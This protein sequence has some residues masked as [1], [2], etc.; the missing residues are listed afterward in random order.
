MKF[1]DGYWM[2]KEGFTIQSPKEV[3][4][5]QK[6]RESLVLYAP[7]KKI[8]RRGD[9]LNLGMSTVTLSSPQSD[10]ISVKIVHH[11][12]NDPGPNFELTKTEVQPIIEE[13]TEQVTFTSG[14]LRVSAALNDKFSLRFFGDEQLLTES[15]FGAQGE[16]THVEGKHYMREQLSLGIDEQ[17][18]GLGERFTPFIK[19]GQTVD[20]W[21]EDGGTGSEQAYKNIPF[22][23]S[24][25]GYGVFVNH[26]EKV[27]FE[28][29]SENVSRA[30]FSVEGEALEYIIIYGPTPKEILE[31]Y[32]NL[33]GKPALPPAWSFG[34]WLSTSFTTDYSEQTVMKFIDGM[35][36]RDIPL[37]VFH[38]DC[39]WM[40]AF[41]WCNFK[42]DE[43]LF[44]DPKGMLQRIHEKG[45]NVCVWINPYIGQK[46]PL[47]EEG[48]KNGYFLKQADGN[49]W[50]WDM[51]Q[52]GQGIVDFTNPEAVK[53]YQ[54][55]LS[56]LL[57][58]GVDSFKTDFG[59]RIPTDAVYY[60]GSDPEKAHNYYSYLYNEA[61]FSLLEEKRGKNEAVLFAR[62]GTVGSQKFPVHWG[63][64]NLSEYVSMTETLRGGLSFLLSGFGFWSHDIGGFEENASADIYKRW[65]QFGL[66]STHS[67]YHGNIEYRVPWNYDEEAVSVTRKF[68]KLKVQL[69]PYLYQQAVYTATTGIPMM[70]PVFMEYPEDRNSYFVD[71]QY[72]LGDNLLV[73]PVFTETGEVSY[74][75]PE[76]KWTQLLDHSFKAV[77]K[78][79]QW[80]TEQHDYL[81]LPVWVKENTILVIAKNE[82]QSVVYD[83]NKDLEI[84]CYQL[85]NGTHEQLIVN[86]SGNPLAKIIIEKDNKHVMIRTEGLIGENDVYIHDNDRVIQHKLEQSEQK[87]VIDAE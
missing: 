27:S 21:N 42:W 4:S 40:K 80:Q 50:Q 20:I 28:M 77:D 60:D 10:M 71:K 85:T 47:F 64:D 69:M 37:E 48:R 86:S 75:L 38:F 33:T 66:L 5:V 26:P 29:A 41:E 83:Y 31:K 1:T 53:W 68:T 7:Y 62:S 49:V 56:E 61:V 79:G 44:P 23:L 78:H 55:Y 2:T 24:S 34:L 39:F 73:A 65:T 58:M 54:G 67:R 22:Y 84:H 15:K 17:L 82:H 45:I 87:L 52:A 6:N 46:S 43:E 74:Y 35:L 32:T 59:E 18:Y 36:E 9:T 16:I 25:N 72:F 30:Q 81:S 13:T 3:F 14:K 70:R 51:W 76:G 63:G 11:E 8:E 57:D 19:N 12:K